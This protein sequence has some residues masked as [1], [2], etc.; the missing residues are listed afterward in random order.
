MSY[1]PRIET[2]EYASFNTI[3]CKHSRLWFVNNEKLEESILAYTA[4]YVSTYKVVLYAL[5]IEGNH[6][7]DL[8]EFPALN[9]SDFM[10][11]RNSVIG[12]LVPKY[13]LK[14]D[15]GGTFERRYSAELVPKHV[16][17][18]EDR[19][20]YTVLQPIQ[21]GLV[22]R[23]SDY[24][25][26]NCFHDAIWGLKRKFK[27]TDWTNYNRARRSNPGIAIKLFQTEYVLEYERIPG[28]EH[29]S[30]RQYALLMQKKYEERRIRIV[31]K[32]LSGGKGFLGPER[33]KQILSGSIPST[34]KKSER[35]SY[36]P[37]VLSVCPERRGMGKEF[38]FSNYEMFKYAS[39]KFR[40]GDLL[41]EFPSGMYRPS[42]R[43]PPVMTLITA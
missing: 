7:H 11:D 34:T 12:K 27:V 26:Y 30:Q 42:C 29:L 3:R 1:P 8:S 14:H 28:Y 16:D 13:N 41:F 10:R 43:P 6:I 2:T 33:L 25:L 4:K 38:Y 32:R 20:F 17:D 18:I 15:G 5:A 21:D 35:Y 31:E 37:R 19:F 23:L 24:P 40:K 39:D 9:R 36:R 22:Q